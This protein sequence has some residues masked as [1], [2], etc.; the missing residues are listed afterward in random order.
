MRLSRL[1]SVFGCVV[2]S[3]M[4]FPAYCIS[5]D[6]VAPPN[7]NYEQVAKVTF[8]AETQGNIDGNKILKKWLKEIKPASG[9]AEEAITSLSRKPYWKSTVQRKK[10]K[11][12]QKRG[13]LNEP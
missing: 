8:P 11:R 7:E 12:Y 3:I 1:Y 2:V 10:R 9:P 4:I 6:G 13:N 5:D